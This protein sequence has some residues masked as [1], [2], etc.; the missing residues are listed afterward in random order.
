MVRKNNPTQTRQLILE[1]A[2]N[3]IHQHGYK[4]MRVDQVV[5]NTG[6]TKGAIYYHFPN[7]QALGYAV[8]DDMLRTEFRSFWQQALALEGNPLE[9]LANSFVN[10]TGDVEQ[11]DIEVGCP[12]TNLG[13]EMSFED[14]GFRTRI[15][16]VFDE[17][18]EGIE[19]LL[20]NG[21]QQNLV[22]ANIDPKKTARFLVAAFQ[23]IQCS[24]KYCK[25]VVRFEDGV[26]YLAELIANLKP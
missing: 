2:A 12:L 10:M 18:I 5:E 11:C 15:N 1:M 17:W 20:Q 13:S 19:S 4:G 21:Q 24:S 23:G 14:E 3:L 8:V 7:K 25:D 22:R 26:E 16:Q 9:V 6:L